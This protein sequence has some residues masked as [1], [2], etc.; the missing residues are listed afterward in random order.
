MVEITN[1]KESNKYKTP[2][3]KKAMLYNQDGIPTQLGC[4]C[5]LIQ[6]VT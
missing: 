6:E 2:H 1:I 4:D 3:K 5:E